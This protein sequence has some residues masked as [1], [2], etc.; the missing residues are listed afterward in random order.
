MRVFISHIHE[1]APIAQVLKASI[2]SCFPSGRCN[3]FESSDSQDV[4]AG[5]K[6][7]DK[8]KEALN[9]V[10]VLLV[11]CSRSSVHRPWINFEAGCVWWLK[12]R[13][14]V[15]PICHSGQTKDRLPTPLSEFQALEISDPN[16]VRN[17]IIGI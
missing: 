5:D 12:D 2:E 10:D 8:I 17:L 7:L 11:L 13:A 6:W 16:F 9:S 14:S 4:A 3:V 1:E 15:I